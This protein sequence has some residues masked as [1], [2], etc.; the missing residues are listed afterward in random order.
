[1]NL[2]PEQLHVAN[3]HVEQAKHAWNEQSVRGQHADFQLTIEQKIEG[4]VR[5]MTHGMLGQPNGISRAQLSAIRSGAEIPREHRPRKSQAAIDAH[6]RQ[7]TRDL[8]P[9]GKGWSEQEAVRRLD[10][11]VDAAPD[12]F[13]EEAKKFRGDPARIRRE[14]NNWNEQRIGY[15]LLKRRMERDM[16]L[17]RER[18]DTQEPNDRDRRRAAVVDAY[19]TGT[20]DTLEGDTRQGKVS[21]AFDEF[22]ERVPEH[23]LNETHDG[24]PTRRAQLAQAMAEADGDD[25]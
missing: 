19:L 10:A 20:A 14:A 21:P 24:K 4:G 3:L 1:M 11:L 25:E 9:A 13:A 6:W 15:G 17:G 16:K 8:D 7:I 5:E 18:P 22:T 23:L 12:R 2:T